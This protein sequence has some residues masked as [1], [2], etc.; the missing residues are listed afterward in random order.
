MDEYSIESLIENGRIEEL[1]ILNI[2]GGECNSR[3]TLK[4]DY[5]FVIW[6]RNTWSRFDCRVAHTEASD[7]GIL[8][9][10]CHR[11][12]VSR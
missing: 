3:R 7:R 9:Q 12:R 2:K 6:Q 4:I 8:Q 11:S 1:N 10:R 5:S